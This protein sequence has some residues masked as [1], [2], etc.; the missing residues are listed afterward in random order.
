MSNKIARVCDYC[1][2]TDI[3]SYHSDSNGM[4][5]V[6]GDDIYLLLMRDLREGETSRPVMD[7]REKAYCPECLPKAISE[8]I[9]K[10]LV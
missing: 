10:S 7:L 9:D 5:I 3:L 2:K 6:Q 1:G 4:I 8:W